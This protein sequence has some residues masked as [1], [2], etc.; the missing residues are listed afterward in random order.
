MTR[1]TLLGAIV[2]GWSLLNASGV[3]AASHDGARSGVYLRISQPGSERGSGRFTGFTEV[4]LPA[5][6]R[7]HRDTSD[8]VTIGLA[9]SRRCLVHASVSST[10]SISRETAVTQLRAGLPRAAEPGQPVPLPAHRISRGRTRSG[11]GDWELIEPP[12]LA[13]GFTLYGAALIRVRD[14]DWAGVTVGFVAPSDCSV[15]EWHEKRVGASLMT[16]LRTT[17]LRRA[18]FSSMPPAS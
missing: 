6:W 4:Q 2:F 9:V 11:P 1:H 7:V 16:L 5:G 12:A 3:A 14:D 8:E 13:R 15:A 18:R 10:S 17:L